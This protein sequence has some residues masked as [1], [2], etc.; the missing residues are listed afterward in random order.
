MLT[1]KS[2]DRLTK[3]SLDVFNKT[4]LNMLTRTS[5]G[6]YVT[7]AGIDVALLR[8]TKEGVKLLEAASEPVPAGAISDGSVKDP[9]I[10]AKA[11]K[12]LRNRYKIGVRR[13]VVSLC[14]RPVLTQIMNLPEDLPS[15]IG[16]YIHREVKNCAVL[17][18]RNISL[19]YCGVSSQS[20]SVGKRVFVV[21][22][23]NESVL[24]LI[25]AVNEAGL[26][27]EA[28][29]PAEVACARA[30][31]E[32]KIAES[33]GSNVLIALVEGAD[34]TL[35]VFRRHTLDFVRKRNVGEDVCQSGEGLVR[36]GEEISAII[37]YY[38]ME[39]GHS[40]Q[41]WRLVTV[42]SR[43]CEGSDEISNML[44]SKFGD[45]DVEVVSQAGASENTPV[46]TD[47]DTPA[48]SLVAVGLAMGLLNVP[49]PKLKINLV[50][51]ESAE[52]KSVK[53]YTLVTAN[54]AAGI[55]IVMILAVGVLSAILNRTNET[56]ERLKEGKSLM[57]TK[58]LLVEQRRISRQTEEL[59]GK[60][61]KINEILNSERC[62]DWNLILADIGRRIPQSLWITSLSGED[63]SKM[64]IRG[65]STSYEAVRLFVDT[66]V[67]SEYL[68]SAALAEAEKDGGAGGL[69]TYSI[70]CSLTT[71]EG[72]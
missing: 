40:P 7:E 42:L 27:V 59:R 72:T 66:L 60:L 44:R 71:F 58:A 11:I 70:D 33:L 48:A 22:A 61:T 2:L 68:T 21:A 13:T 36:F 12:A 4:A 5:L 10:L 49:Q 41:S 43:G 45:L 15:N 57:S 62:G 64:L 28:V 65:R 26:S 14:A 38:D 19:D 34:I 17:P 56:I 46:V 16:Q 54:I 50:P 47:S 8:R 3:T 51:P 67:E 1:K 18:R 9:S 23:E 29:E 30:L 39:I 24:G 32:K 52:I 35:S 63:G 25:K 6:V 53:K 37:Q 31:Y 55:L 69:V 20:E